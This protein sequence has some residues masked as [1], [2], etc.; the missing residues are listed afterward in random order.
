MESHLPDFNLLISCI[1]NRERN[2]VLEVEDL[3]GGVVGDPSVEAA[4]TGIRSLLVAKTSIAPRE[5]IKRLREK[6]AE[7]PWRFQYTLK[8]VPIDLVVPT[9]IEMIVEGSKKIISRIMR[10]ETF[11]V[12][13]NKRHSQL[14]CREIVASVAALID[15]KVDLENPDKVLQVE[16][17][18][19]RTGLVVLGHHDVLSLASSQISQ[20]LTS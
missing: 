17:L 9:K 14:H 3:V 5:V 20:D 1:R 15:S 6:A 19:D 7:D 12:T 10:Q 8:Y 16:V 13:C 2:A 4:L 11:R 18:G